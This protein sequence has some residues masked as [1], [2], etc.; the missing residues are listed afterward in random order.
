MLGA[1]ETDLLISLNNPYLVEDGEEYL[2]HRM[3]VVSTRRERR[4]ADA[5]AADAADDDDDNI[6]PRV[7]KMRLKNVKKNLHP[8]F[9]R[10]AAQAAKSARQ[11]RAA[12]T[13]KAARN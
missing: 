1:W 6:S 13:A 3:R 2:K 5:D 11:T 7:S 4:D 8:F 12:E 9:G 10:A